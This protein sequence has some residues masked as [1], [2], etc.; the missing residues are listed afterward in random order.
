MDTDRYRIF[1]TMPL[2]TFIEQVRARIREH[3]QPELIG[4]LRQ[5]PIHK[6]EYFEILAEIDIEQLRR[7][8]GDLAPCPMCQPNK[9]LQRRLCWFPALQCC[10]IIDTAAPTSYIAPR[11]SS[12]S[13][14]P[15]FSSGRRTISALPLVSEKVRVLGM[16]K[17]KA[18]ETAR[19]PRKFRK[20]AN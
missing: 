3:G 20:D 10:A 18:E 14:R 15:A 6:D 13:R 1:K 19:L 7:P 9:F 12:G 17:T 5:D 11:P 16:L 8:E 4:E 2:P